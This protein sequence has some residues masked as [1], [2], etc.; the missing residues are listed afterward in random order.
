MKMHRHNR[1][2][3]ITAI[4]LACF[5][6]L[7]VVEATGGRLAQ[8][9]RQEDRWVGF[10][11]VFEPM[12]PSIEELEENP[13]A[14]PPEDRSHWVE[15]GSQELS[16]EGI[17][18]VPIPREI[19][20]GTYQEETGEF[21]FPRLDG[22]NA[23]LVTIKQEDGSEVW[24]GSYGL[25]YAHS[26]VGGK[27]QS[28]SG[29][30]YSGP[31]LEQEE[32]WGETEPEYVWRAYNVYQMPDGTVYLDGSGNSYG[33]SSGGM[34]F[35]SIATYTKTVNGESETISQTV[36]V[37]VEEVSRLET[38]VV[39]SFGAQDQ[40]LEKQVLSLEE[41]DQAQVV[42]PEECD[43]V[44]VEEQYVDGTIKRTVYN[45]QDVGEEGVVHT[46]VLLDQQGKGY[47]VPL[48]LNLAGETAGTRE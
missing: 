11:V 19:L 39:K 4:V 7:L 12:P 25:S 13:E 21:V 1:W 24:C 16:V 15:Y 35:S 31:P 9:E 40:L 45:V 41:A 32:H 43:W 5:A 29:T 17:G 38:V 27:E 48:F 46:L 14:Y 2:G 33:V 23:F 34:S 44:L 22:Y 36:E 10:Q 18:T 26:S 30:I 37:R 6:L 28:L 47:T 20:I 8:P 42:L 3:W